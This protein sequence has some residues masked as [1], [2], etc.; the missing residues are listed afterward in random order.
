M[1][2]NYIYANRASATVDGL[3]KRGD[4]DRAHELVV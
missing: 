2:E 1:I 3:V 4:V